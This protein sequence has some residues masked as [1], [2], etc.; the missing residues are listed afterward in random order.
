MDGALGA[1]NPVNQVE[2]EATDI[3]CSDTGD[4]KPLVQCFVSIGTGNLGKKAIDDKILKFLSKTLVSITTET[5]E[6]A[7]EFMGRWREHYDLKRYFRFNV[8]HGLQDVGLAEYQ[9]QGTIE[10]A[11][12]MYL[13]DQAQ[14]FRIR[15]CV[16]NMKQKQSMCI[17][18]F[19]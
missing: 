3:W 4:L 11:T 19:V 10:T 16:E 1:N 15:D 13:D 5:N 12:D 18:D 6:T 9:E 7:K 14:K 8:E 2:G 17:G